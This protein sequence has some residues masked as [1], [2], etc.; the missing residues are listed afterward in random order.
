MDVLNTNITFDLR[1]ALSLPSVL[2][3]FIKYVNNI[4]AAALDLLYQILVATC[5][6]CTTCSASNLL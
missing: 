1:Q 2:I 6:I 3:T 5:V 4:T